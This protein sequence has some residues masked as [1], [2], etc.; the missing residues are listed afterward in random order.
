MRL[1]KPNWF[2]LDHEAVRTQFEGDLQFCNEFCVNG[3]YSPSAVYVAKNPNKAKG[4]KKYALLSKAHGQWY[5]RG[6]SPQKMTQFRYQE[7]IHCLDCDDVIY[8]VNR[9]DMRACGC[10]KVFID[11]GKDYTKI[12]FKSGATFKQVVIDLITDA[13]TDPINTPNAKVRKKK[14]KKA[15]K[16]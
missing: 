7:A 6:M 13:V 11:G 15:K 3:E 10:G 4:H 16:A 5:I 8:S 1:L 14:T 12:N 2:G 9:H